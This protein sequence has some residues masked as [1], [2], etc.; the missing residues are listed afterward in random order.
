VRPIPESIKSEIIRKYLEGLSIRQISTSL[1]VSVGAV[2]TLTTEASRRDEFFLYM[3]EMAIKFRTK[4]LEFS[5]V[6]SGIRLYNKINELGLTSSFFEHFLDSTNSESYKLEIEHDKFLTKIIT[7]LQFERQYQINLV[8]IPAYIRDKKQEIHKIN[9]EISRSNQSLYSQYSVKEEEIKEYL[10]EKPKLLTASRLA[11]VALPT[12]GDWSL[13]PDHLYE[14]ALKKS[15]IK[16]DPTI[17]YKKLNYIYKNPDKHV[18]IIK[19]ILELP[20][21]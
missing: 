17:L 21:D 5:D 14:K 13:I 16:I 1:G 15:G 3:R 19:Q 10:R 12:H 20:N 9:D 18:D 8:D 4:N 6:I 7:I 11:K 2:S